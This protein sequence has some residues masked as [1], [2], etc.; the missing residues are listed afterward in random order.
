MPTRPNASPDPR[1][2]RRSSRWSMFLLSSALPA[3]EVVG[4]NDDLVDEPE[5]T[6]EDEYAERRDH[7]A[8]LAQVVAVDAV[9]AMA[10]RDGPGVLLE[11]EGG[12]EPGFGRQRGERERRVVHR[13][14]VAAQQLRGR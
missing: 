6:A 13:E 7:P 14:V 12:A 11:L 2:P 5:E 4:S 1:P 10:V 8:V 9:R 3:V